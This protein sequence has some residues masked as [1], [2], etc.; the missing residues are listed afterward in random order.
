MIT[1]TK[2]PRKNDSTPTNFTPL[3]AHVGNSR[4]ALKQKGVP[5]QT[6]NLNVAAND[7]DDAGKGDRES[8]HANPFGSLASLEL[9]ENDGDDADVTLDG[10][11]S[12]VGLVGSDWLESEA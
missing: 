5:L 8:C 7:D 9:P 10:D 3:N 6:R 4:R 12:D 11:I 2:K 1:D